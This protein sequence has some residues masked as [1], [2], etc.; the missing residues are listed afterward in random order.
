MILNH[1]QTMVI[2][3]LAIALAFAL[4]SK[5]SMNERVRYA[6]WAFLA[7]LVVALGIGWLMYPFSR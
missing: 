7:F 4:L 2:F 5:N 6:V 3:A 1:F